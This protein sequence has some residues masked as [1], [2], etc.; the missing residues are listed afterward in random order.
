MFSIEGEQRQ[1][2]RYEGERAKRDGE[3]REAKDKTMEG[4]KT[5]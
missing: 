5:R 3:E 4:W 2:R 1:K